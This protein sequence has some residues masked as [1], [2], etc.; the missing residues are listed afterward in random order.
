[1]ATAHDAKRATT[2]LVGY[3]GSDCSAEAIKDLSRAGLPEAGAAV[4]IALANSTTIP[5]AA[6]SPAVASVGDFTWATPA[7]W[8]ELVDDAKKDAERT[9][10]A[11]AALLKSVLPGWDVS[12]S[13]DIDSPYRA[14]IEEAEARQADLIVVGTHGRSAL[15]RLAIG[16]TSQFVLTH[17]GCSV[18]VGRPSKTAPGSPLRLLTCVDGSPGSHAAVREVGRRHW[19]PR[20]E[21]RLLAAVDLQLAAVLR[22]SHHADRKQI[23]TMPTAIVEAASQELRASGIIVTPVVVQ[24]DPKHV[25]IDEANRWGA[26][27]IFLGA[28]GHG[29]LER[30]L[31]G[32]VSAAVAA[33]AS[34][35]VEVVRVI[36]HHVSDAVNQGA[37]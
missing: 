22:R 9:A 37:T 29:R 15:G 20:T 26:D 12:I 30:F 14:L 1:M 21:A 28:T 5:V 17:A 25:V 18:R 27:S 4:V 2:I 32:S 3:D 34:C 8:Q 10:H 24:G 11:G 7:V 19:P 31:L 33:R 35:S 36:S 13:H 6:Y 16:S 23:M